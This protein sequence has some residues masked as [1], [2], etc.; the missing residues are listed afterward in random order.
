MSENI[1]PSNE[2]RGKFISFE[3]GEGVGKSTQV[4]I[5]A[6]HLVGQGI[7]VVLTR[8]PG[9]SVGAEEIRQLLLKGEAVK[10]DP[11]TEVLLF[12]AAR[13]D[14]LKK[15]ILPALERG[16]W[17]ITDRY[18]DSTFAYQGAG[19]GLGHEIIA[20]IHRITTQDFWPDMTILLD[21][22]PKHG[23]AR[24]HQRES[25]I[26]ENL[27]EDRFEKM[28]EKYHKCLRDEFLNIAAKN[29]DRFFTV[30][31]NDTIQKI[32]SRIWKHVKIAFNLN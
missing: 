32:D 5:L 4:K 18:A 6:D 2:I 30:S 22:D 1:L 29:P 7:D 11:M 17:V 31:A 19:H 15:I 20:Q 14:H 21:A 23:L 24:A 10:W 28:G 13:V 25:I 27:R 9:G 12:Y 3:G 8:E 26:A 16:Q